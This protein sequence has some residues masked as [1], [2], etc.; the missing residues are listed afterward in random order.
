MKEIVIISGKGGTGKTSITAAFARLADKHAVIADCDVD[1]ANMHI[2]THADFGKHEK[3][4]SGYY[5][6]IDKQICT[7]CDKCKEVCHFEAI[8]DNYNIN[9]IACEGCGYCA[10]VCPDK[11]IT[12]K[13]AYA[14]NIYISKTRFNNILVHAQLEIAAENSGKIVT[15][16]KTE[17]RKLAEKNHCKILLIDGSPGIGCPVIASLASASLALVITEPTICGYN[18][19]IR[20]FKLIS[21][22]QIHS[23][24]LINKSD[25]SKIY[26]TKIEEF[27][28]V[29]DI[30]II[31]KIPY[32]LSFTKAM[33]QGKTILEFD[34]NGI[35]DKIIN[36]WGTIKNLRL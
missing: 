15:K 20:L 18:D 32:H 29:K 27:A 33:V 4:Y 21:S 35:A 31:E 23:A 13:E 11:S 1:A 8:S 17:A 28:R 3:F 25:L 22:F 10:F 30:P 34:Q 14:G 5:A 36:S 26:L 16:V 9:E 7:K 12:M 2:L 6:I 24:I 19:M